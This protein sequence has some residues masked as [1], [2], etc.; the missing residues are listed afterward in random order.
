MGASPCSP[1]AESAE[2]GGSLPAEQGGGPGQDKLPAGADSSS[3]YLAAWPQSD[4]V[5]SCR[6]R[7]GQGQDREKGQFR[8]TLWYH[9]LTALAFGKAC[10]AWEQ[11]GP[12]RPCLV[13]HSHL[14]LW[15]CSRGSLPG[16]AP[17]ES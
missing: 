14:V 5:S 13:S 10:Q 16:G 8:M 11:E 1:T 6:R 7:E 17:P 12:G 2:H 3:S 9:P 15:G 4:C